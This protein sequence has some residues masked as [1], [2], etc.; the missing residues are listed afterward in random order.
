MGK[1][2]YVLNCPT[3]SKRCTEK[4]ALFRAPKD[5]ERLEIWRQYVPQK[6]KLLSNIHRI[7][8]R[9]FEEKY[10]ISRFQPTGNGDF[11]TDNGKSKLKNNAI[12]TIFNFTDIKDIRIREYIPKKKLKKSNFPISFIEKSKQEN[13]CVS[14]ANMCNTNFLMDVYPNTYVADTDSIFICFQCLLGKCEK[15]TI[16]E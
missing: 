4:Y 2:C 16:L 1:R 12:P 6:E 5:E 3:N 11:F 7:C 15:H 10:V 13:G 9:H 14:N 8:E